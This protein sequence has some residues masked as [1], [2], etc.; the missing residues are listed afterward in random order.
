MLDELKDLDLAN[1]SV[2]LTKNSTDS[3]SQQSC[4][5]EDK[6]NNL[7]IE[8]QSNLPTEPETAQTVSNKEEKNLFSTEDNSSDTIIS[9]VEDNIISTHSTDYQ[10]DTFAKTTQPY[11]TPPTIDLVLE[12][13]NEHSTTE[14]EFQVYT[15][16]KENRK[17]SYRKS[18]EN[19]HSSQTHH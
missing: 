15:E 5:T 7:F 9:N 19:N 4:I 17:Q 13:R 1:E 6:D 10:K 14:P 16:R 3:R 18:K 8:T 11:I 2:Q 12:K